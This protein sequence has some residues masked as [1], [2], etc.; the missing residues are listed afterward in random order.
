[1]V[2]GEHRNIHLNN[3]DMPTKE[4]IELAKLNI[5]RAN[6]QLIQNHPF[7][8]CL[9]MR[10]TYMPAD[11]KKCVTDGIQVF[12][13][14]DYF[15]NLSLDELQAVIAHSVM[16]LALLHH[17][18]RNHRDLDKWNEA[19]DYAIN[20]MLKEAKFSLPADALENSEYHGMSA[21]QIYGLLPDP[22]PDPGGN[23]PAP[24]ANPGMGDF[25]DPPAQTNIQ[26]AETKM[27]EA[28]S[29]AAM[30]SRRAGDL[31]AGLERM[32]QDILEPKVNWKEVLARF[33][34]EIVP[35][36]YT[37]TKPA[38]R[39]LHMGVFLPTL[40]NNE[41]G[42]IILMVD[43][44]GSINEE[45]LNRVGAEAKDIADSF[46][47]DLNVLYVD[48]AVKGIQLID[49]DDP[50]TLTPSGGGGTDF[51][52]GFE[53]VE[54]ND[55][56]PKAVIYLTDGESSSFP[57]APDYPVLWTLFNASDFDPPFGEV[58]AIE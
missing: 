31:T 14:P 26:E 37:W 54:Q 41:P 44:S 30:L 27:Q 11:V 9:S 13:N 36:D 23:P 7:F 5:S 47:I 38:P 33:I 19:T 55:L 58:I 48:A 34:T 51:Q 57:E 49:R 39:Y 17:T 1:M 12:Y 18:R 2:I 15:N 16:H 50:M 40:E 53:Y 35:K 46:H 43:T 56:E 20:P 32:V 10:L 25:Q 28:V 4:N 8:A 24:G 22:E 3:F 52:P 42:M 45:M 29:A 21:E 6:I